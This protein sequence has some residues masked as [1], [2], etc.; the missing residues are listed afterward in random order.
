ML[1]LCILEILADCPNFSRFSQKIAKL[2]SGLTPLLTFLDGNTPTGHEKTK[3]SKWDATRYN[4]LVTMLQNC[5]KAPV[6]K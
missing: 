1:I 6:R 2:H 5:Q 3:E 4:A